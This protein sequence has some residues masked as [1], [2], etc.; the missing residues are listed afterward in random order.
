MNSLL[1]TPPAYFKGKESSSSS[2][3]PSPRLVELNAFK[4]S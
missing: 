1:E 3:L 4:I 2:E